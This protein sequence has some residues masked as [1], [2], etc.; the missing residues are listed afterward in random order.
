[1]AHLN[2]QKLVLAAFVYLYLL[3]QWSAMVLARPESGHK[4]HILEGKIAKAEKASKVNDPQ[5][6]SHSQSLT[7]I[8]SN[9]A[10]EQIKKT[11]TSGKKKR[12]VKSKTKSSKRSSK[13]TLFTWFKWFTISL[14]DPTVGGR[15]TFETKSDNSST[16]QPGGGALSADQSFSLGTGATF[17]P[18]CGP[19]GCM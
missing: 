8:T 3:Q 2:Q 16:T 7:V 19:N 6:V 18:V 11:K 13:E 4:I 5:G 9:T 1:M 12:K 15:I 17:G 14:V 10:S